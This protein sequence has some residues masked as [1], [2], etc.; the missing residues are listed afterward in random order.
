MSASM[1][2]CKKALLPFLTILLH[3]QQEDNA[4]GGDVLAA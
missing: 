4:G 1:E 3:A 2:T